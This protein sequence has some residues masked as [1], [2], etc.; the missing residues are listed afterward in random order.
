MAAYLCRCCGA[1]LDVKKG[2]KVCGCGY[3]G[4]TQ[5][6]PRLDFDEKAVLWERADALRRNGE[7]DRAASLY[8]QLAELDPTDPDIFWCITLC[9]FGVEYV[10]EPVSHKRVPTI[11]RVQ[12]SPFIEDKD[13]RKAVDIADGDQRRIYIIQAR[14]LEELRRSVLEVSRTER[15]YDIFICYKETDSS[16]R[17]TEIGRA[18]CRERV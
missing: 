7:F 16:G 2:M 15:P 4:I 9:R 13:Y 1:V 3:C 10:E 17:R 11:N 6:V 12:Y 18:S 5:T 14:Q 8:G